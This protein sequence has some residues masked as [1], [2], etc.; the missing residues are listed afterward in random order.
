MEY[1]WEQRFLVAE[2]ELQLTLMRDQRNHYR[3]M[4]L[5]RMGLPG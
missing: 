3:S 1:C 5:A 2:L 4:L